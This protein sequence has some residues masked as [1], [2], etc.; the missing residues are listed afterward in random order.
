MATA[1]QMTANQANAQSS[2]GPRTEEGKAASSQNARTHGLS[3]PALHIPEHERKEYEA[4]RS[5]LV[6][7]IDPVGGLENDIFI[8]LLDASWRLRRI[9]R[10]EDEIF[11][12]EPNPLDNPEAAKKMNLLNRYRSAAERSYYKALKQIKVEQTNNAIRDMDPVLHKVP[13]I[14]DIPKVRKALI[15]VLSKRTQSAPPAPATAAPAPT[16]PEAN[17]TERTQLEQAA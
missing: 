7:D 16:A 2:T 10:L 14:P 11:Q 13:G 17:S 1:A 4:H 12:N 15:S 8:N 5:W 9:Q 6:K 3:S